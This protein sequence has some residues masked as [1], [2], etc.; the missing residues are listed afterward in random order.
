MSLKG[1]ISIAGMPG[2]YKVLAQTKAGFIVESIAD[3]NRM[4]VS[5]TQ[6]ISMLDDISIFT[7]SDD[8]PLKDVLL[9]LKEF[10]ESNEVIDPKSDP[11]KLREFF[12]QIIPDFDVERV[13]PSD[14]KKLIQWFHLVKDF[15]A[16]EDEPEE[17]DAESS[18][19]S[20]SASEVTI[21]NNEESHEAETADAEPVKVAKTR[22]KKDPK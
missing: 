18:Q 1:V 22:K 11:A 14:I 12:K 8:L 6:K 3:K 7:T 9:K 19:E 10:S 17:K 20:E 15:V 16:I 4:P 2:L 13:Y 21:D 5:S